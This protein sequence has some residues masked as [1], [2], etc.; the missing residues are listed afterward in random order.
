MPKT[1][2][3]TIVA[4]HRAAASQQRKALA[5]PKK[6]RAFLIRAGILSKGGKRLSKRYR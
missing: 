2:T 6:A 4:E 5:D 1:S 3:T